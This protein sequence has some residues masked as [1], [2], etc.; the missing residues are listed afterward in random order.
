M[1]REQLGDALKSA[2]VAQ[3]QCATS[4]VRLILAALKERDERARSEGQHDGLLGCRGD[5]ACCRR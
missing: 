4:V 3:D 1:I 2:T 5:R